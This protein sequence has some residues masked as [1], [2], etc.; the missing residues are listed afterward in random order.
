MS[1]LAKVVPMPKGTYSSSTTY[2]SLDI[3]RYN[4]KSWMCKVD[5]TQNV[6]PSD[7]ATWMLLNQDGAGATSLDQ[8]SDVGLA[9]LANNDTLVYNSTS[10]KF[11][12]SPV[13]TPTIQNAT[14]SQKGIMQVGKGLSVSS[15]IVDL[16]GGIITEAPLLA[17][18]SSSSGSGTAIPI[19]TIDIVSTFDHTV[20]LTTPPTG[21]TCDAFLGHSYAD[22]RYEY[23]LCSEHEGDAINRKYCTIFATID[24]IDRTDTG[25]QV[26]YTITGHWMAVQTQSATGYQAYSYMKYK[27]YRQ[28]WNIWK[29]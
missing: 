1:T 3:V 26:Y 20:Y 2:N 7:G 19:G 17:C 10:G 28:V 15:G 6:T 11:E 25:N 13:P 4:G 22:A 14:Y 12:N 24:S 5:N 16:Q 29:S 9:D 18:A 27:F 23:L 21:T 8:L